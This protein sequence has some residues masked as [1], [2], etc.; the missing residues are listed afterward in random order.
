MNTEGPSKRKGRICRKTG[1]LVREHSLAKIEA[2]VGDAKTF[3]NF[4]VLTGTTL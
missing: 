3:T 2:P 4:S 1:L